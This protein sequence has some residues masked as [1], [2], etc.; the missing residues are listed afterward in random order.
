[1]E[2][3]N[4]SIIP[5]KAK[6]PKKVNN[7][8]LILD[9][10]VFLNKPYLNAAVF[11]VCAESESE[12]QRLSRCS[13]YWLVKT[14]IKNE[15]IEFP[16]EETSMKYNFSPEERMVI[17]FRRRSAFLGDADT[18]S[19]RMKEFVKKYAVHELTLVTIV[20][21]HEKRKNSYRLIA[22]RM[23]DVCLNE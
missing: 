3:V 22:E 5:T 20:S 11:A 18:V 21:D 17:D 13:E 14:F 12:A 7:F 15:N 23:K 2:E 10:S 6:E 4:K 8:N 19:V 1:V 16:D 9:P